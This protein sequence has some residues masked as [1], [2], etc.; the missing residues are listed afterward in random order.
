MSHAALKTAVYGEPARELAEVPPGALQVSPLVPGA[1]ALGSCGELDGLVMVAPSGRL[2]R[3]YQLALGLQAL[4]SGAVLTAL[5]PKDK[6]GARLRA[7]LEGFGCVV[8]ETAKRHHRICRCERPGALVGVAQAV[9]DGGPQRVDALSLWSQPGV[10]SWDRVDPGSALLAQ[11]LP[12]LSGRG[13]DFGCGV[14]HLSRAVLTSPQVASL[15]LIDIDRRAIDAA[16]RNVDDPRA[17]LL[18]TDLTAAAGSASDA[19]GE[20]DFVVMNPPFHDGGAEDRTLGQAFIRRAG[21]AL[22]RGGV[23]WMVA[24]RHLPYEAALGSLFAQVTPRLD[25]GGYK[26]FEA[27]R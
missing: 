27:H 1:A 6:G 25:Q 15:S 10:F 2:E 16:R 21:L 24:N 8:A 13:A 19:P 12:A 26:V 9:A 4:R 3:R 20:L 5:A 17:A 18:W 22:R 14:G 23:L 11:G 7:E